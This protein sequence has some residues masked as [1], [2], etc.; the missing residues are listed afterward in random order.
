MVMFT[1]TSISLSV[2]RLKE[3]QFAGGVA[4][5]SSYHKNAHWGEHWRPEN[6]FKRQLAVNNG[7]HAGAESIP[8]SPPLTVWYDFKS[9]GIRAAEVRSPTTKEGQGQ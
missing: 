4:G 7:W 2:Y 9:Q 1:I 3:V 6:A 8:H 5:A